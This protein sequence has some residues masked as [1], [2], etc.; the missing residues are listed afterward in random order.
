MPETAAPTTAA[1][2]D[3]LNKF[4]KVVSGCFGY[5]LVADYSQLLDKLKTS[6]WELFRVCKY[7][8]RITLT[9]SW[10][11]HMVVSHIK[12]ELDR[13]QEGLGKDSEQTGEADHAKMKK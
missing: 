5:N 2:I 6:I 10:K 7:N 9:V 4:D 11:L 1:I 12:P 8:L 3:L 13:T